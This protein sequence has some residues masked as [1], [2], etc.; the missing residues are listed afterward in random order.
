[1]NNRVLQLEKKFLG[2][3]WVLLL[4]LSVVLL[5]SVL[6]LR[7]FGMG[8][9]E[10]PFFAKQMLFIGVGAIL[11]YLSAKI[12]VDIL[13]RSKV[14]AFMFVVGLVLLLLLFVFGIQVNGATSWF[15]VGSISFQ[16]SDPMKI[17]LIL[18]L[19]KYLSRR[20]IAIKRPYHVV[21][22]AVYFILPFILIFLQPDFGSAVIL[23]AIW[24]GIIL[25][26]GISWRHLAILLSVALLALSAMW[27][28]VFEDYQKARI[29]TFLQPLSDIRGVGY[30][31]YQSTVAV[32]SGQIFGKGVGNGTQSRLSFLPENQ[33]DFIWASFAEEWG[34]LGSL[35]LMTAFAVI[36]WRILIVARNGNN[37]FQRLY[38]IGLAIYLMAHI[39][40]NIGMNIGIL[41]VTGI[42]LPFM[43]YG[44]SHLVTEFIGIGILFAMNR[45]SLRYGIRYGKNELMLS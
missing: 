5:G 43:S 40:I 13:A 23:G 22:T 3:D 45:N 9:I 35:I 15:Q 8:A 12:D 37:N 24:I 31:A 32:G 30:N 4:A 14:I 26:A 34:F 11:M 39:F 44:G 28:V 16:P 33:T 29:M 25:V 20:H 7:S 36:I 21:V 41:P 10:E 1:M 6:T 19:S 27:F 2:F 17:V 38:A 42:T 18:I